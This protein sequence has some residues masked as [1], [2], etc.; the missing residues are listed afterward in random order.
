MSTNELEMFKDSE[1]TLTCNEIEDL[2]KVA[3][4][5]KNV[6]AL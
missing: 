5:L 4:S 1:I 6:G 2:I 3:W